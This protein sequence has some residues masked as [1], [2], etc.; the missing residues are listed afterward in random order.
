MH[1]NMCQAA[2][3]QG[4]QVLII[5]LPSFLSAMAQAAGNFLGKLHAGESQGWAT[6]SR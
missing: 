4:V 1:F 2:R 6:A 3:V 5:V